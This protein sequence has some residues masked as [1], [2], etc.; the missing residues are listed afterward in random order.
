VRNVVFHSVEQHR[1]SFPRYV[2]LVV[3][4]GLA[5]Y[6][7]LTALHQNLGWPAI[8]AKISAECL[9]FFA[10]FVIQRDVIFRTQEAI[11]PAR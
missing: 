7:I 10:N 5:S 4:S 3:V 9:L 1:R 8:W 2:L 6:L 11:P